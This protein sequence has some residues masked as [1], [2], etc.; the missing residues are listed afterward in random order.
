MQNKLDKSHLVHKIF[1]DMQTPDWLFWMDD[2]P[3]Q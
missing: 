2:Y 3:G 1:P